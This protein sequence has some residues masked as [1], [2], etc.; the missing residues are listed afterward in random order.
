MT[1]LPNVNPESRAETLMAVA[2]QDREGARRCSASTATWKCPAFSEADER[3]PDLDPAYVFD[4]D[5]TLAICAG[6]AKNR[7][8]MV[9]GYHGTGKSTHIEQVAARLNW[10]MIRINLDAHISRIDLVGRDA[11]VLRDGQQ[12]TEFREGLLPW[13][14]QH[15]VALVFDEYDAGRPDVMFVIQRVLEAEGKLTLLDQ[16]RVI[17]PNPWFRLFATTNTV[18]LGDTTGL[19]HGTQAINQGQMDRWNIVT[20]LNYLPAA[21]EAQIVLAKSG[22]YDEPGGKDDG[23][24]DDQ[25][26]RAVAPGL[27]QRRHLDRDEPAHGDQLGAERASSSATSASPSAS[28]FLN[29][30]DEA[31]RPLIAEYYQ[32]VFGKDLPESVVGKAELGLRHDR[33]HRPVPPRARR[34]GAGDRQGSRGRRRL[35]V[36][37]APAS[38]KTARVPSPGPGARAAAGRRGARR[39]GFGRA[40]P[41]PSRRQAPRPRS[42][43]P[44]STRA[45]C[46]TRSRRRGSRRS[47]RGRWAACAT[48]SP[49]LTEARVR[50][51]A[52]VRARNA[53]EVPL[54]TAVGL[55]ARERLT[56]EAPPKAALRRARSWSRR[57]SRRKAAAELD[58]LALT[59]DD[60]AAFAKLSRRLLEDLD[61]AA[62]EDPSD[63]EPDEGGDDDEGDDGGDEDA[64]EQGDEGTPGRRRRRDARRGGRGRLGRGARLRRDG[65]RRGAGARR[66]RAQRKRLRRRPAGAIGSSRR[67]PTTRPSPPASTRSSRP[68]ELCDE[69]ELGR[70]RAY[71]DQQ[72]GGLAECRHPAR[73]P[74]AAAAD[75][76]AGAQ[77]GFRPGG[78]ACSTPRGWR[79][80]SSI[81][82]HAL[83]AT[84]SSA[85]PSSATPSSRC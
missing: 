42:R 75:G 71:L 13:A 41:A 30:C 2:R 54:A 33:A 11:I 49:Q 68:S 79:G 17:R 64:A 28:S 8:V 3:V 76:A 46:S 37:V 5:T 9:Q 61:L 70:L 10:P 22:E 72:M 82:R 66:R 29:K 67:R 31:E 55:I 58:A 60:Q 83:V 81:P 35:R 14:L 21:V 77:L 62:A 23:R 27:H 50:G 57:G 40:A 26:R 6:F 84:R 47:A 78:R 20:T 53:E 15:P 25:G 12:V 7:R 19:Y 32:R 85:T 18:G 24:Q 48:I 43:R 44:I 80:W 16:N 51:D 36:R 74:A 63:D 4:P 65:G 38:G 69:E 56:G 59:L 34:R 39:R 73:Q 45:R 52:I 1:D